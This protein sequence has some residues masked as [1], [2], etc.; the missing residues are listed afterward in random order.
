MIDSERVITELNNQ[1]NN[2]VMASMAYA[3][4]A[5]GGT[6]RNSGS[7]RQTSAYALGILRTVEII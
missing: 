7:I 4:S 2:A 1:L 5:I 6:I 3:G